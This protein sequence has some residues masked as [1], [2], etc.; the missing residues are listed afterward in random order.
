MNKTLL[1]L[2]LLGGGVMTGSMPAAAVPGS[3]WPTAGQD[4]RDP[5]NAQS[6]T[7]DQKIEAEGGG[8]KPTN[9][10]WANGGNFYG[11][12]SCPSEDD[13]SSIYFKFISNNL[14]I[15]SGTQSDFI[16]YRYMAGK[17]DGLSM[18]FKVSLGGQS[19]VRVKDVDLSN[20]N[21]IS[22]D[23]STTEECSYSTAHQF[24]TG[25][26]GE[27]SLKFDK[28]FT[29]ELNINEPNLLT[30]YAKKGPQ[31]QF[32]PSKPFVTLSFQL[33][34]IV[35]PQCTIN[36]GDTIEVS[37]G[38]IAASAFTPDAP[39]SK[40]VELKVSCDNELDNNKGKIA[41][42]S[43][44]FGDSGNVIVTK[45]GDGNIRSDLGIKLKDASSIPINGNSKLPLDSKGELSLS[46]TPT[47]LGDK[48]PA[49]GEFSATATIDLQF[50]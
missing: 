19:T 8:V 33:R 38:D 18:G 45:D 9:D 21:G 35:P 47:Q 4:S 39:I 10:S 37:F 5:K 7:I 27:L 30:I 6:F 13:N 26:E 25:S 43:S 44:D 22:N 14:D 20:S 42:R 29:G 3:C 46:A 40:P 1:A 11:A 24:V 34:V 36:K 50:N 15:N 49:V 41:F 16:Y 32:D 28:P 48:K 2:L 31:G 23:G 17:Y 12:C